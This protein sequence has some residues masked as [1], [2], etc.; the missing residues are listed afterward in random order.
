[1]PFFCV[2]CT[3]K[4]GVLERRIATRPAHVD[5]LKARMDQVRLAGPRLDAEGNMCGSMFV[6]E[7]EDLAAAK[8]FS[9][10]D[11]YTKADLF[12]AVEISA[13][14]PSLGSWLS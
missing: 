13:F 6:I 7:A 3:D 1:M 14:N 11:P 2:F 8:A 9:A 4:P 12:A 5:Y 10:E